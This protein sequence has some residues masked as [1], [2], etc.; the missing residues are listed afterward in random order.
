DAPS[1]S[2]PTRCNDLGIPRPVRLV[3]R[4]AQTS[5]KIIYEAE[6][7]PDVSAEPSEDPLSDGIDLLESIYISPRAVCR[8]DC[9]LD[10]RDCRCVSSNAGV[11]DYPRHLEW[12]QTLFAPTVC[13]APAWSSRNE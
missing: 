7:N 11:C 2:P 8:G 1:A 6:T 4:R 12:P 9:D 3:G 13:P 10:V 5:S